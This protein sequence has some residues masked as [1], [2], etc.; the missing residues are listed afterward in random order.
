MPQQPSPGSFS[1]RVRQ[2]WAFFC[3]A[4]PTNHTPRKKVPMTALILVACSALVALVVAWLFRQRFVKHL[5]G[6]EALNNFCIV[7]L[8]VL[9]LGIGLLPD[10]L[11]LVA[12]VNL[13]PPL[14]KT[15]LGLATAGAIIYA[16]CSKQTEAPKQPAIHW[17]APDTDYHAETPPEIPKEGK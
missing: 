8:V 6:K 15:V 13:M 14:V 16:G 2:G 1:H 11:I 4:D 7:A 5:P 3:P 9:L 12:T 17:S 10:I